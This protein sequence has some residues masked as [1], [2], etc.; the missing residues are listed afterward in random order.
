LQLWGGEPFWPETLTLERDQ[1]AALAGIV[2]IATIVT[3]MCEPATGLRAG[4][5]GRTRILCLGDVVDQYAGYNSFTV[6]RYDPIVDA[7]MVPSRPDYV[8]GYDAAQKNMRIYMPRTYRAMVESYDEILTSDADRTV[9]KTEWISWMT[10]AVTEG[11]LGLLWLGSIMASGFE[12]WEST[13]LAEI[14]PCDPETESSATG[15]FGIRIVDPDEPLMQA[16]PWEQSPPLHN[17]NT[18]IPKEGSRVWAEM[19]YPKDYPLMTYWQVDRGVV[20]CFSSKFPNGVRS[21]ASGW[22]YFPQ[23]MSYLVYRVA[24]RELPGDPDLFER[25]MGALIEFR[26]TNALLASL[27]SWVET[28]GGSPRGLYERLDVLDQVKSQADLAYLGGEWEEALD[29]LENA[30]SEQVSIR[31]D[32][33]KAKDRALLW[34]YVIEWCALAAT[35][36]VSTLTI[37]NLMVRRRLYK[38]VAVSRLHLR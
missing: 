16:L 7:T 9:F 29:L 38:E 21:W 23:A 24:D 20:L 32:A 27:M 25:M 33:M 12:S 2:A 8:G 18:Q 10:D 3:M 6:I 13:T 34:V 4:P 22:R 26:E 17:F 15:A 35:F 28:F 19:V 14:A 5:D 37:W 1:W 11:G 31:E 30:R 36:M